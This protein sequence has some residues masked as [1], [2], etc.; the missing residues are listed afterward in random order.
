M[1]F[2]TCRDKYRRVVHRTL[3]VIAATKWITG[4]GKAFLE[5]NYD[6]RGARTKTNVA[7]SVTASANLSIGCIAP[8]CVSRRTRNMT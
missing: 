4:I 8:L 1:F 5:I 7:L 2:F 3:H 6:Q